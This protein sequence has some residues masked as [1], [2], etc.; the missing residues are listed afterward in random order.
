MPKRIFYIKR[1]VRGTK[2]VWAERCQRE[3][4]LATVYCDESQSMAV[5]LKA[6][7]ALMTALDAA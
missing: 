3:Q 4:D 6:R 5:R 2:P 1:A 7:R